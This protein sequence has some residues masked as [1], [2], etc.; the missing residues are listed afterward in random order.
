MGLGS[1]LRDA[2]GITRPETVRL[3]NL[4]GTSDYQLTQLVASDLLPAEAAPIVSKST[5]L[6]IGPFKKGH[7][8]VCSTIASWPLKAARGDTILD[9]S[10]QPK[11]MYADDDPVSAYHRMF[12]TV[13]DLIFYDICV[14][15][16]YRG[17]RPTGARYAPILR[18][19]RV[20]KERW[21]WR[22]TG[23]G[24]RI[25]VEGQP[26]TDDDVITF[27]GLHDGIGLIDSAREDILIARNLIRGQAA[28]AV[29][30]SA[31]W[32]L[33]PTEEIT[34]TDGTDDA[35]E[36]AAKR[37]FVA[38]WAKRRQEPNGSVLLGDPRFTVQEL[39]AGN[40]A[41][42][43]MT[44]AMNNV[45]LTVA[46]HLGIPASL[47]DGSTSTASLTYS[48]QEG[49]RNEFADLSAVSWW[50]QAIEGRLSQ[51]DVLVQ[52][53]R[54]VLDRTDYYAT[55][56]S[57]IGA[58]TENETSTAPAAPAPAPTATVTPIRQEATS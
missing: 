47:L 51:A 43:A 42:V 41:A 1:A 19:Q 37:A 50:R 13:S 55:L 21:E 22:D 34:F 58:D 12:Y 17:A 26:M 35:A 10:D 11:W 30:S 4:F 5:A 14:W 28:K 24:Y 9:Y 36:L 31:A 39:G 15:R 52:G 57:P 44:E 33:Q 27:D 7:D 56:P 16:T 20:P 25:H 40:D 53:Q 38:D 2:L 46:N 48:T 32:L 6:A 54:A 8:L 49:K 18:A 29:T 23:T 45:R 3:G